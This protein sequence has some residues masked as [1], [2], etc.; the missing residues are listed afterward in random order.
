M[1][2][3]NAANFFLEKGNIS[4][5]KDNKI[6][7][8][9]K[10]IEDELQKTSNNWSTYIK[11]KTLKY[12]NYIRKLKLKKIET[13]KNNNILLNEIKYLSNQLFDNISKKSYP[14]GLS[15]SNHGS[16]N[17]MRSL[18]LGIYLSKYQYK[19]NIIKDKMKCFII[20]M[21]TYFVA[22]CRINEGNFIHRNQIDKKEDLK[23]AKIKLSSMVINNW[24]QKEK[25]KIKKCNGYY[26]SI[27]QYYSCLMF[28]SI[29]KQIISEEYHSLIE[30][31]GFSICY[32]HNDKDE[33]K[34]SLEPIFFLH[35][36]INT[37]HYID[38]CRRV[39]TAG[40]SD[41]IP[42][43]LIKKYLI[44]KNK[45]EFSK[46]L[47]TKSIENFYLSEEFKKPKEIDVDK[48]INN[49]YKDNKNFYDKNKMFIFCDK[50]IASQE[51]YKGHWKVQQ[52]KNSKTQSF[53]ELWDKLYFNS[54]Y[55]RI[56]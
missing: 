8:Y 26:Q 44:S 12:A 19:I 53:N 55:S 36:F 51:L 39:Y 21:A 18:Y 32:F 5:D 34:K 29:M 14:S 43:T 25:S 7:P 47:L 40:L 9:N 4:I 15:R 1:L 27:H 22:I 35:Y 41:I 20:V 49:E 28:V 46:K 42:Q 24:F 2:S 16:Y 10:N 50:Y 17:H 38:H 23:N 37:P 48:Y 52:S 6:I 11:P 45:L 56:L 33:K 30:L 31:C 54:I 13:I 3:N